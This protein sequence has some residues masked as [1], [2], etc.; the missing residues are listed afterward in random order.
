MSVQVHQRQVQ[1]VVEGRFLFEVD[2][3]YENHMRNRI[4][5]RINNALA[6][7]SHVNIAFEF[8]DANGRRLRKVELGEMSP[9]MLKLIQE[10]FAEEDEVKHA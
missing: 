4:M 3:P 8:V 9:K 7:I 1:R 10:E 5:D 6:Q 2:A